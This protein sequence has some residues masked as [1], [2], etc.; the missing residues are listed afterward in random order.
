MH[1]VPHNF[2]PVG[3]VT[4]GVH[5]RSAGSHTSKF[6]DVSLQQLGTT[7]DDDD[8]TNTTHFGAKVVSLHAA[9]NP[10][11]H[12]IAPLEHP[13]PLLEL[14]ELELLLELDD[15]QIGV[16]PPQINGFAGLLLSITQQNN[17]LPLQVKNLG[18]VGKFGST[19]QD[20]FDPE[21]HVGAPL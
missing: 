10:D 4:T 6:P 19:G 15:T 12:V 16:L 7:P 5:I 3:Q 8:P 11:G 18:S 1:V 2:C 17:E 14:D 21:Q 9:L 13:A 20:G